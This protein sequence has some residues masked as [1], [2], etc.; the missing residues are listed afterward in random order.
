MARIISKK[1]K[2]NLLYSSK[3]IPLSSL[4]NELLYVKK[5]VTEAYKSL[6]LLLIGI[7]ANVLVLFFTF[8]GHVS[9]TVLFSWT[10]AVL[11]ITLLRYLSA[12][13][14]RSNPDYFSSQKWKEILSI[15]VI[16]SAISWG[17]T[18]FLFFPS[19]D[20]L[21]QMVTIVILAG[22]SAG[23]VGSLAQIRFNI[24][25]YLF[26]T[27]VPLII[28]L[29]TQ[30]TAV[31]NGLALLVALYLLLLL[32]FSEKFNKNYIDAISTQQLYEIKQEELLQSEQKFKT[33][34][35][36]VPIGLFFY[37]TNMKIMEINPEFVNFLEAPID[38]LVGLD[39]GKLPDSRLLPA[40]Q[41][42]LDGLQGFYEG[43]YTTVYKRKDLWVSMSTS[44]L[45][46]EM[47]EIIGAIGIVSDITQRMMTQKRMEHQANYDALTDIPNRIFIMRDIEKEIVR[48]QRHKHL[49]GILFLDLDNFKNIND[50]LGHDIGDQLLIQTT[51]R[52][53]SVIRKEDIVARIG[54][55]EFI[56]ML[57]DLTQDEKTAATK[58][59]HVAKKIH[60]ALCGVFKLQGH[61]L[62]ISTSIGAA[63]IGSDEESA[64]DV[65]KHADLAMYQAKK[66]GRNTTRFYQTKMDIWVR[67]RLDIENE[68]RDAILHNEFSLCYQPII[69]FSSSSVVGAEALLRWNNPKLG[70]VSPDEFIPVAEESG[71]IISIGAWVLKTA[72]EQFSKWQREFPQIDSLTKI[73]INVSVNQFNTY[74]FVSQI[75]QVIESNALNPNHLELELTESI[76]AKDITLV[77][78]KM[79]ELREMGIKLSIDDFGT[80]YSS[81]SY[82]KKLPFTTLKIDKSFTQ[83]IQDD[84]DDKELI[85]TIITIADN[86]NLEVVIEGV[87]TFE[88]FNF[89]NERKA[90]YMQGYYCSKPVPKERFEEMLQLSNGVC[91]IAENSSK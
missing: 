53:K 35:K 34:F 17:V 65:V 70:F 57:P 86:F 42:P 24:I 56:V 52:I 49:F 39:I 8:F 6:K 75:A 20:Y 1:L 55:D 23:S 33:I 38:F 27:L 36:S 88:Q 87:E 31:H 84:I 54:G 58:M 16:L 9:D 46:G 78:N 51:Q 66:D 82:L 67:R 44:P 74:D 83:D 14:Y 10:F 30:G 12:L 29:F 85:S 61:K 68:L 64:D 73:A 80:G 15:G 59:E 90:T 60:E 47:G 2:Q 25:A 22:L 26:I 4:E 89:V 69:E 76:I 50:S 77:Q 72:V 81:L 3:M 11:A 79:R 37:D 48:Y 13:L 18:P 45:Y 41:A 43:E 19:N 21:Y 63:I 32:I 62:T 5:S 28:V 71:I 91:S 7:V 40:L